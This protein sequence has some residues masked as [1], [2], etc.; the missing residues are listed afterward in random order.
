LAS[1]DG[2]ASSWGR[3]T[4]SSP[5]GPGAERTPCCSCTAAASAGLPGQDNTKM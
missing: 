5:E 2:E 4:R 1:V 3:T